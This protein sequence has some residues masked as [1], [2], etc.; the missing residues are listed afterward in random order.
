[1]RR[2]PLAKPGGKW[3]FVE[4]E[5]R[6]P[7]EIRAE[8]ERHVLEGYAFIGDPKYPFSRIDEWHDY[9]P[10][11]QLVPEGGAWI[12][13]KQPPPCEYTVPPFSFWYSE[14]WPMEGS[15]PK[16]K[17][18]KIVT[19][20]GELGVFPH[21]YSLVQDIAKYFEFVGD[22]I[23]AKFFGNEDGI[24]KEPLF[25][26]RSRGIAK[27]DAIVMLIGSIKAHGVLWLEAGKECADAFGLEWPTESR[28]ATL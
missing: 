6:T 1:M 2:K 20:K 23:E 3:V 25:Y 19:P 5:K 21:E 10:D 17:R 28:L 12:M 15:G 4:N 22:G 16:P 11:A 18:V 9:F 24:P 14:P 27:R 8:E 26:L 13:I 7:E